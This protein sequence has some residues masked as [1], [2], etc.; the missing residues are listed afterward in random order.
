M[1]KIT[2]LFSLLLLFFMGGLTASAQHWT[3]EDM[4]DDIPDED[5]PV[6]LF[7]PG[8]SGD[9]PAGWWAG[10]NTETT[11]E[12]V[13]SGL[14]LF[15]P[16][17]DYFYDPFIEDDVP[18]FR[19]KDYAT[20][21][22]L[23]NVILSD[24]MDSSDF[25]GQPVTDWTTNEQEAF[26]FT[27]MP[28]E[29]GADAN[30]RALVNSQ[31]QS[32]GDGEFVF[33]STYTY[34]YSGETVYTYLG[35]ITQPFLSPWSDTNAWQIFSVK[36]KQGREVLEALLQ[37][38]FP[39]GVDETVYP[40]GNNPG[41]YNAEA[42]NE[43]KAV[44]DEIETALASE[45][46]MSDEE[47]AAYLEALEA[48]H[49]KI[50]NDA[51]NPM[52]AGYYYFKGTNGQY[53]YADGVNM[54]YT[55]NETVP[56][57]PTAAAAKFIWKV[58]DAAADASGNERFYFQN[59]QTKGYASKTKSGD[60]YT[61]SEEAVNTVYVTYQPDDSRFNMKFEMNSGYMNTYH[62]NASGSIGEWNSPHD[63]GSL[64]YIIALDEADVN[65]LEEAVEAKKRYDELLATF[66]NAYPYYL[67]GRSYKADPEDDQEE[68]DG[69][70]FSVP[71][72]LVN[73]D[74]WYTCGTNVEASEGSTAGLFD[75]IIAP[76]GSFVKNDQGE[77]TLGIPN[78]HYYHT[79]WSATPTEA[80][81]IAVG[82]S[83]SVETAYV[84][85][86]KRINAGNQVNKFSLYSGTL[87]GMEMSYNSISW[88]YEGIYNVT[89]NQGAKGTC[90]N[91]DKT[92]MVTDTVFANAAAVVPVEF[93][94]P[95]R[96]IKIVPE[97]VGNQT[98]GGFGCYNVGELRIYP[99]QILTWQ[100]SSPL[101]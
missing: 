74:S 89:Y 35:A 90:L 33:C 77:I 21:K 61:T 59:F 45:E 95:V 18:T 85:I 86:A 10:T 65:A 47:V 11:E 55:R 80:P 92:A 101:H 54:K 79:M 40:V 19:L 24:W 43:V 52:K 8:T 4:L 13:D 82:L 53:M 87:T 14:V 15:E 42:V 38:Y 6:A 5:T 96:Y 84:K 28:G 2:F 20:G 31:K 3:N 97:I 39:N 26:V 49:N 67:A 88:S 57:R 78:T 56:E 81:Y 1:K 50:L 25:V 73:A 60:F 98:Y 62:G 71:T 37:E 29:E 69:S 17:G 48:A 64:W 41:Q 16:T 7:H 94:K 23:K 100:T 9:S 68:I 99:A 32:I 27:A 36:E 22:Y 70:D 34:V 63:G 58:T 72:S 75:G 44:Y 76:S 51:F 91:A 30:P 12:L 83:E 46:E 66:N 93:S